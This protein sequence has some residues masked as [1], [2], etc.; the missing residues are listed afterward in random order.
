MPRKAPAFWWS[1][2]QTW[3]SVALAPLGVAY[4][5]ITS[6]RMKQ[7]SQYT[8]RLPVICIGNFTVGG[9]GKTPFAL[10]LAKMLK[11]AGY[12]PAFLLRG[13]G[14]TQKG[15][16]HVD[17]AKHRSKDVGDEALL[18]SRCAP[19]YVSIDRVQGAKLIEQSDAEVILMD[20]GFQNPSLHKDISL[21]VVDAATGVGNN[22][23]LP[24]G[25]LRAPVKSQIKHADMMVL[26]G[27]GAG[28][29]RALRYAARSGLEVMR[30]QIEA[31]Y[32]GSVDGER[33]VAFAG[34]GRPQK[35]F[36]T[37]R[38]VGAELVETI[39]Y[40]DHHSYTEEDAEYIL[41]LVEGKDLLPVTTSKDFVRIKN[42]PEDMLARLANKTAVLDVEMK[43]SDPERLMKHITTKLQ[44]RLYDLPRG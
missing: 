21:V 24:A 14:G 10:A 33:V 5:L 41:S 39:E 29:D 44:D 6:G 30:A 19:T 32:P 38:E 4:G 34:I 36:D 3:Q 42:S 28:A 15:A 22:M 16:V 27:E 40:P 11:A 7:A 35:V 1:P 31:Q 2:T 23:C 25:P 8:S 18:L 9:S 43:I 13:Y 20:D 17:T 12:K 37:L 26:V